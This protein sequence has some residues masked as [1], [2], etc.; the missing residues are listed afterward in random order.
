MNK[1]DFKMKKLIKGLLFTSLLLTLSVLYLNPISTSNNIYAQTYDFNSEY[2]QYYN[3]T[4]EINTDS[5]LTVTEI[6]RV[7]AEGED[8]KRGIYR[9]FP[10]KYKDR[11]INYNTTFEVLEVYKDGI[12]EKYHIENIKNGKRLYIGDENLYLPYGFYSYTIKYR[13]ENQIGFFE[14]HD[15]LY[16]NAIGSDWTFKILSGSTTVILPKGVS[17][18]DVKTQAYTGKDG[19]YGNYYESY[20]KENQSVQAEF[21]LTNELQPGEGFSFVVS[22]PKGFVKEPV[23]YDKL[24]TYMKSDPALFLS[25]SIF[26]LIL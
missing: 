24:I 13:T 12:P 8:I 14:D 1:G 10:T 21:Y 5:S 11:G 26:L 6:I 25:L 7:Y 9:D 17:I 18:D 2:I 19:E 16:F 22:W 3:S 4:I 20:I 15:E 23:L